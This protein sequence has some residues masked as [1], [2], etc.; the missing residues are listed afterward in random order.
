LHP[1]RPRA[2]QIRNREA[3]CESKMSGKPIVLRQP[4]CCTSQSDFESLSL[5]VRGSLAHVSKATVPVP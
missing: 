2:G 3:L 5:T 1:D 4:S